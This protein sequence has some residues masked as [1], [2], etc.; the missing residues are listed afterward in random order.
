MDGIRRRGLGG[1]AMGTRELIGQ[2][3]SVNEAPLQ[4]IK[5]T[6]QSGTMTTMVE[7]SPCP[8]VLRLQRPKKKIRTTELVR[9]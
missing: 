9:Y 3:K 5:G 7:C 1:G 2:I 4:M 8:K 6:F